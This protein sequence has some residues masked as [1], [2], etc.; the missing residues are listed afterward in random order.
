MKQPPSKSHLSPGL[1]DRSLVRDLIPPSPPPCSNTTQSCLQGVGQQQPG[2]WE[3]ARCMRPRW[4][5][6]HAESSKLHEVSVLGAGI[7]QGMAQVHNPAHSPRALLG[8]HAF[9][10]FKWI[11]F[12]IGR[13]CV[14]GGFFRL[15]LRNQKL[16]QH[17]LG[18]SFC[19]TSKLSAPSLVW[20][21]SLSAHRCT[22]TWPHLAVPVPLPPSPG[23]GCTVCE[24]QGSGAPDGARFQP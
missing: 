15:L 16:W 4:D 14:T 1:Q 22:T 2:T 10:P 9:F 20:D 7:Q 19:I 6:A 3:F 11:F 18:L 12:K 5:V 13:F 21:W 17:W 8:L 24:A 23:I